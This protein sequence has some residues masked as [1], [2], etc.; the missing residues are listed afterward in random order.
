[1][2]PRNRDAHNVPCPVSVKLWNELPARRPF[3]PSSYSSLQHELKD[4]ALVLES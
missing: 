4:G 1:M 3:A 2:D